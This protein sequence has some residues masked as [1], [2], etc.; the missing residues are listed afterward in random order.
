MDV[1]LFVLSVCTPT[2]ESKEAAETLLGKEFVSMFKGAPKNST[3]TCLVLIW[4]SLSISCQ[5]VHQKKDET[6]ECGVTQI[7]TNI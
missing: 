6:Y 5:C 3:S 7:A 1:L 4:T 2:V